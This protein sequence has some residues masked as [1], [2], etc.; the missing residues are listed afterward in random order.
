MV[1][2]QRAFFLVLE[3]SNSFRQ[4]IKMHSGSVAL[5][6][7]RYPSSP[8]YFLQL[9]CVMLVLRDFVGTRS[10]RRVNCVLSSRFNEAL[11]Q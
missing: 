7:T 5:S 11:I 10:N 4:S 8:L 1:I 2:R 9:C 6:R 3:G